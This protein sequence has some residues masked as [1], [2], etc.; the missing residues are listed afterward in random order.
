MK[1]NIYM[2]IT[3]IL[4][5]AFDH[6]LLLNICNENFF[7]KVWFAICENAEKCTSNEADMYYCLFVRL[8]DVTATAHT[9]NSLYCSLIGRRPLKDSD[10]Q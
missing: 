4:L 6:V 5:V 1:K 3:S 8:D 7:I 10:L 2:A 9:Q